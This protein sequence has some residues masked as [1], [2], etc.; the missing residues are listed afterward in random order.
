MLLLLVLGVADG[1]GGMS[2][3]SPAL[4][5]ALREYLQQCRRGQQHP[6]N[7]CNI[8]LDKA[9][10]TVAQGDFLKRRSVSR[11]HAGEADFHRW[12]TLCRLHARSRRAAVAD[13]SDWS[14]A[15]ALDD[16]MRATLSLL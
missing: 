7:T 3:S 16:A 9:V 8:G 15:L 5:L 14:S 10:L 1:D 6:N 2:T 4:L 13:T 11:E 12:L